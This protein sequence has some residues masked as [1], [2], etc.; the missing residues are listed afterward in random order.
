MEYQISGCEWEK[1]E[2][3]ING[4]KLPT[5]QISWSESG[6]QKAIY[7]QAPLNKKTFL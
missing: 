3:S 2:Q 5:S 6:G 7:G 1:Y 4:T